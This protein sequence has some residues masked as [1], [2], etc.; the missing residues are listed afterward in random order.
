MLTYCV[1]SFIF[2]AS[3]LQGLLKIVSELGDHKGLCEMT[4]VFKS[5]KGPQRVETF[6][7]EREGE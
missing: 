1:A 2:I 5:F 7:G 3:C 4:N 6:A